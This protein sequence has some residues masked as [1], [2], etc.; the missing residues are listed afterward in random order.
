MCGN[1]FPAF[2]QLRKVGENLDEGVLEMVGTFSCYA[3]SGTFMVCTS[4]PFT[5]SWRVR[6]KKNHLW[7]QLS[8][9]TFAA[10]SVNE[11]LEVFP[12]SPRADPFKNCMS[13][14]S[15]ET[16]VILEQFEHFLVK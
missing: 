6:E 3:R 15:T 16:S 12:C 14:S 1:D 9:Y 2:P 8:T 5:E 13:T 11:E 10:P 4:Y 7:R